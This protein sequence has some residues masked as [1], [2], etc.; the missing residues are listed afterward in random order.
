MM[1]YGMEYPFGQFGST[2]LAV[3]PELLCTPAYSVQGH[4]GHNRRT[5]RYASTA[6]QQQELGCVIYT[7]FIPYPKHTTIQAAMKKVSPI[8]ARLSTLVKSSAVLFV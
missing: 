8:A 3:P 1:A 2:V 7:V 4:S 5:R 6:P